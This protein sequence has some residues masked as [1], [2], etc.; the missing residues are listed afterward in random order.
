[1]DL[2]GMF[3]G[4]LFEYYPQSTLDISPYIKDIALV[5]VLFIGD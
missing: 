5:T 4:P 3:I 2:L 1:M